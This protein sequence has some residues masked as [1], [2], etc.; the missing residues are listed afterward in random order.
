MIKNVPLKD[1]KLG[2]CLAETVNTDSGVA[3]Y[4][5][6]FYFTS[7]TQI[8]K[9]QDMGIKEVK[10]NFDLSLIDNRSEKEQQV[11][12][13][14]VK[15]ELENPIERFEKMSDLIEETHE[16]FTH[17]EKTV[18]EA[19]S[20]V[21]FGKSLNQEAI[22]KET[23]KILQNIQRDPLV[24]LALLDLKNFD[25]YT[26]IHSVNVTVLSVAFAYHLKF[27]QEKL[28]SIGEGSL[29]HDIGKARIPL[30]ILNKPER[31]N[32]AE[33][34]IIQKHPVLGEQVAIK[35]HIDNDIIKEI[36]LHHHESFDGSGYPDRLDGTKMKRYASIVAVADYYDALTSER[37]YK[38]II[39]PP[40][41]IKMI[42]SQSGRKF[43]PRVVNHFIKTVGIYPIGSVV[44][45]NDGRIAVVIAFS[46][47]NLIQPIVKTLF[48][49]DSPK[50]LQE[51]IVSLIDSE[52]YIV[53]VNNE[54][55]NC[56]K[57]I[58][59]GN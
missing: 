6:N 47:D 31:L 46:K 37:V 39:S 36:I 44:E 59:Q 32:D 2:M 7:R 42:Y 16:L 23:T 28:I 20:S 27:P 14:Q 40:D 33:M 17:S 13:D 45:L 24:S 41:A 8:V 18:E 30:N 51:E 11:T 43:D 10:I 53:N 50:I 56:T 9:L 21:R 15:K 22:K 26:F 25:E 12:R 29:L 3:I 4:N 52:Y 1:I 49:I 48:H 54:F 19:M 57:D 34:R 38:K 58:F 5:S 35:E 55:I